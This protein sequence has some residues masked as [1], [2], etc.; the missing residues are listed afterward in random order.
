M[1]NGFARIVGSP[2]ERALIY[3]MKCDGLKCWNLQFFLV[4]ATSLGK[5]M[6]LFVL[7]SLSSILVLPAS[8]QTASTGGT[9][10]TIAESQIV[11]SVNGT[12]AYDHDLELEEIAYNHTLSHYSFR[13]GGS[14]GANA[15]ADWLTEQFQALG[16]EVHKEQFQFTNW[17][18]LSKPQLVIDDDGD[19][20][21]TG[22]QIGFDSFLCEHFSWPTPPE[23]VFADLAVLPLPPAAG[24]SQIG[25]YPINT[26]EWNAV[27][28]TGKIVLVGREVRWVSS[29]EATYTNKL[30][31]Q[32]PAAV[33][34]CIWYDWM[35][36]SPATTSSIGGRPYSPFGPYYWNLK[37]PL[38]SLGYYDGLLVR[39]R[40]TTANVS[41]F[42]KIETLIG[43]GPH[44][45]VVG[46]LTGMK[47]PEK[48]V[49][50]SSH[51]DT[52]MDSGFCDNGAGTAGVIEVARVFAEANASGLLNP[53]Y[54]ILFV[55]WADEELLLVG[56]TNYVIQHKS[57]MSN[58][59]AVLNMDCIGSDN[60]H[61]SQTNPGPRF[62]L[63]Q[64]V[65]EA[66]QDLGIGAT[67]ETVGGSDQEVFRNPSWA[68]NNYWSCWGI[69]AGIADAT[70]VQS[71]TLLISYPLMTRD[72]FQMGEPGWIHT[73]Y[74]NSTSTATLNWVEAAD[75]EN[76][77]RVA[78]LSIARIVTPNPA[79][80]NNDGKVDMK[81]ISY[82]ARRFMMTPA[83]P[84]W[85]PAADINRDGRVDM[86]DI[87][88]SARR[89]GEID[90]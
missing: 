7:V 70:A 26:T 73:S 32:P 33:V 41:A 9:G 23:G 89:F 34:Y 85:D 66:A 51:Y 53:K 71:S 5:F 29:W 80:V 24:Y 90:S 62:D 44:Y 30:A 22:D 39:N 77:L 46:K 40:E 82:V 76:Q 3:Q 87:G 17:E 74:D 81:D 69:N 38:G 49:L 13:S 72:K 48:V 50:V 37:I 21:T 25:L 45:N 56:A 86:K 36:H 18:A 43:S 59:V 88:G 1:A 58:I 75:L 63:D 16:L 2:A 68:N 15:T 28:T 57:E 35:E 64:L 20:G 78:A 42:V 47:Y 84:L 65:Y 6:L 12:R 4:G 27:N 54:T 55:P 14:S 8:I 67:F 60:L 52:V 10:L 31:S 11:G 61:I 79:D 83:D 19:F